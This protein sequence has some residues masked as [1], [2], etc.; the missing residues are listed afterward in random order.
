M[1]NEKTSNLISEVEAIVSP[2]YLVG[3]S[4]RDMLLGREPKDYDFCTPLSPDEVETKV[5]EAGRRAYATGKRFGTIGFK[6]SPTKDNQYELIEVTTFRS[7]RYNPGS[8]KPEVEFVSDLKADLSRRDF[9]FNAIAYKDGEYIDPFGGRLDILARK[10]KAVGEAKDRFKEDP[11]RML[12][13]AR[14]AAQLSFDV[15]PNMIGKIRHMAHLIQ[16]ISRERWVQELDKL[17]VADHPENGL[18]MLVDTYLMKYMLPEVWSFMVFDGLYLKKMLIEE[19]NSAEKNTDVRWGILLK[20]IGYPVTVNH[21][22]P[23]GSEKAATHHANL[24][25]SEMVI[26]ICARLKFSTERCRIVYEIVKKG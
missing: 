7:E 25:G 22:L 12:R 14:F 9:T 6:V 11:L 4:V 17:L 21:V 1:K 18:N 3:G 13:A 8:R 24:V 26:G 20:Y 10:I 2:V 15:D 23:R 16:G 5:K 19:L